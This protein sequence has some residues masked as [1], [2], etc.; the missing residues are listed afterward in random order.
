M[1]ISSDIRVVQYIGSGTVST[2][3]FDFKVFEKSDLVVITTDLATGVDTTLLLNTNYTVTLNADQNYNAGGTIALTAGALPATQ[4]L[5]ISSDIPNL[6]PTD[7]SNQGG[8]YPDVINNSLDRAT[9]QIQQL[10]DSMSRALVGPISDDNSLVM[11]LPG[12]TDRANQYLAFD[13]DGA[14]IA[15]P[16]LESDPSLRSELAAATGSSLVGFI[17]T[18]AGATARTMQTKLRDIVNVKDYGAVGDGVAN[19][20]AAVAAAIAQAG[21][22]HLHFPA[23]TYLVDSIS[24]ATYKPA[25]V[26]GGAATIKARIV[27]SSPVVYVENPQSVNQSFALT[28]MCIDADNKA[29]YGLKIRGGQNM[30][31]AAKIVNAQSHGV[32]LDATAGYGIYYSR[33]WLWSNYNDGNGIHMETTDANMR[34]AA[35]V[36]MGGAQNNIGDGWRMNYA[37]NTFVGCSAEVNNGYGFYVDNSY[38]NEFLGGYS[39]SNNQNKAQGGTTYGSND[40][41]FYITNAAVRAKVV[42]GRHVGLVSAATATGAGRFIMPNNSTYDGY[43]YNTDLSVVMPGTLKVT[44]GLG[45]NGASAPAGGTINIA[46][47]GGLVLLQAGGATVATWNSTTKA[48]NNYGPVGVQNTNALIYAGTGTPEA[49][50]TA[51]VG[52]LYLRT[53][54]GAST[55]LYVKQSGTGNTGWVAK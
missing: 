16:G 46:P 4:Q 19:D 50:V 14:P 28:F 39:E 32:W 13:V 53:D 44:S 8:F 36:F 15:V 26:D 38:S 42:G 11:N 37:Q 33:F 49:A 23:G 43:Q 45:V 52:S 10:H 6:Q 55:T 22:K 54:G 1:T 27:T 48:L 3:D 40:E 2:Y 31:I 25:V 18:G 9:I 41:S 24:F 5:T 34:I 47:S 29:N 7:L 21:G 20:T 17:A 35:N 30:D 51:A 12:A